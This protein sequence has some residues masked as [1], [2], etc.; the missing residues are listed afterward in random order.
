MFTRELQDIK[1]TEANKTVTFECEISKD[2]LKLDWYR[3]DKQLRRDEKHD[4]IADGKVHRLIIEKADMDN[5]GEY[6]A[7]YKKTQTSAKL[8]VESKRTLN[9]IINLII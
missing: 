7:F 5:V 8:S 3:G 1:I 4:I 6:H 2:G 9:L